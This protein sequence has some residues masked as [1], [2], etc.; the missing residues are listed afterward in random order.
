MSKYITNSQYYN[1][2][3]EIVITPFYIHVKYWLIIAAILFIFAG[4]LY[5][6]P[7]PRKMVVIH[8]H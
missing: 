6:R 2:K 3:G 8:H 5:L 1:E 7:K 4:L